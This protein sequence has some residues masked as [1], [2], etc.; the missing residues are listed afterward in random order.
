[1]I[2]T[3]VQRFSE[4]INLTKVGKYVAV[5]SFDVNPLT[6][7]VS[8]LRGCGLRMESIVRCCA[9]LVRRKLLNIESTIEVKKDGTFVPPNSEEFMNELNTFTH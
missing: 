1:M 3:L 9:N 2:D 5:H 7:S 6:Y 4:S 8:T